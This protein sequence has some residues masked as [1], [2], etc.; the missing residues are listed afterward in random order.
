MWKMSVSRFTN[1][2]LLNCNR[3]RRQLLDNT[4][5]ISPYSVFII[6]EPKERRIVST[7]IRDRVFQRSLC[8]NY[9]TEHITKSFIYDNCACQKG[10]GTHFAR[11]RLKYLLQ[12][13]YK[14]NGINGYVLQCDIKNFFGSTPHWVAKEAVKKR[15][16]DKWVLQKVN[17]II[18]SFNNDKDPEI[19][20]GLGSQVTQ[21]IQ[22]AVLDDLDH[23]IK[24]KL[25]IKEY[26]RYNDDF[27][28]LHGDKD[29]LR[30]CKAIIQ[31]QL[32]QM[33]FIL[34]KKKTQIFPLYRRVKFLGFAFQINHT[35]KCIIRL[36][37]EKI[38]KKKRK[39]K[40]MINLF[41]IGKLTKKN[42][43]DSYNSWKS[44][45]KYGNTHNFLS[46]MNI[47]YHKL[48]LQ[49]E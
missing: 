34:S 42:M 9:L 5:K 37:H 2:V 30:K 33:G 1:N 44:H 20:M 47:F 39:L 12:R 6:Y 40:R 25:G 32:C 48:F 17:D 10:K 18:D 3:L 27:I 31:N 11:K 45:I 38:S 14:K 19:G 35:G 41:F 7:K 29:F 21:I 22:L 28:L 46:C 24:E 49:R 4:Y 36:L 15:V 13:F 26:I 8:D 16:K 23:Y 43:D